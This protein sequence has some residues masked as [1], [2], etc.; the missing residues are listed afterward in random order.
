MIFTYQKIHNIY[1]ITND[2][3]TAESCYFNEFKNKYKQ[4]VIISARQ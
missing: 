2:F 3:V 4:R 1:G